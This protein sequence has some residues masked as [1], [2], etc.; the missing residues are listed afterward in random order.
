MVYG[1]CM[2][3][4]KH[5]YD[6]SIFKTWLCF[7]VSVQAND[8]DE[9]EK[10]KDELTAAGYSSIA[11]DNFVIISPNDLLFTMLKD[12]GIR[13]LAEYRPKAITPEQWADHGGTLVPTFTSLLAFF[14]SEWCERFFL[15]TDTGALGEGFV[16]ASALNG[17]MF[18]IKHG[19]EN[20]GMV[21]KKL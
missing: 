20:C 12:I 21:P 3:I 15:N 7:G 10:L 17:R 19:G 1:E 6:E 8:A 11:H 18:K 16:V 9:N 4:N 13:T 5:D 14:Q 2:C